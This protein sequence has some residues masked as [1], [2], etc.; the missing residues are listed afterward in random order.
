MRYTFI[1]ALFV[2][3]FAACKNN[4]TQNRS[5][6]NDASANEIPKAAL[7][8]NNYTTIQW[9]DSLK[10]F[11][12]VNAGEKVGVVFRFKNSGNKPLYVE[13]ATAQC[14]CTVA[15]FTQGA[16]MP[17]KEGFVKA[18]F[19]TEHQPPTVHK[20]VTVVTNTKNDRSRILAFIGEV[21]SN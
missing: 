14:G 15:E 5:A 13:S 21:K 18:L 17:G 4:D 7:D 19:N 10:D 16:V 6:A 11:G 20:T 2:F 1:I 3:V 8:S 9:L 12:T